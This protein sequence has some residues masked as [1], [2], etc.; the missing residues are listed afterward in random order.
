MK[1][2]L[3]TLYTI[4]AWDDWKY[5]AVEFE[6]YEI[7][8][9][10]NQAAID[11]AEKLEQQITNVRNSVARAR[12]MIDKDLRKKAPSSYSGLMCWRCNADNM[13][14][15]LEKGEIDIC[16]SIE[17][18]CGLEERRWSGIL[19]G[20]KLGCKSR[21]QCS[22]DIKNNFVADP[23]NQCRPT[24]FGHSVCRQCC[25]NDICNRGWNIRSESGWQYDYLI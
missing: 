10:N 11:Y 12:E 6:E 25:G 5:D 24:E 8:G 23:N 13:E 14:Q 16:D 9:G 22:Y 4:S 20:L 15:C 2:H 19:V 17:D 21:L 3:L 1:L 7:I 18:S